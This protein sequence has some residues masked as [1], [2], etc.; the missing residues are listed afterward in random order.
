V[1]GTIG[2]GMFGQ[3]VRAMGPDGREV[4]VKHISWAPGT[5]FNPQPLLERLPSLR[6]PFLLQ[7]VAC[8]VASN[9]LWLVTELADE[10]LHRWCRRCQDGG[11]VGI[12]AAPLVG[13]LSEAAEALDYLRR[14]GLT[15][16]GLSPSNLLRIG[17]HARVADFAQWPIPEP[18][19]HMMGTPVY[20]SP[21]EWRGQLSA[22]SNQY[23]LATSYFHMRTG[24]FPF[25]GNFVMERFLQQTQGAPDLTPLPEAERSVVGRALAR[26][27]GQRYGGCVEMMQALT[28]AVLCLRS[29]VGPAR[30]D[31]SWLRW[32]DGCVVKMARAI[33]GEA[34]WQDLPILADALQ[35]A[36]CA[37]EE[38]L[39]HCR[40]PGRHTRGCWVLRLCLANERR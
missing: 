24:R 1:L 28:V 39:G 16:R 32:N 18:V 40:Q 7:T 2:Y 5:G 4:A 23:A 38:I 26:E 29:D 12:P 33:D 13:Y 20:V 22:S 34:R 21:E 6:H 31:P 9:D 11:Q 25:A 15:H 35:E 17:D 36:G 8:F 30:L 19:H 14:H 27:P 10:D 37:D 3:V